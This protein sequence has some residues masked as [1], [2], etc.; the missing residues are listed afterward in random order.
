MRKVYIVGIGHT[1]FGNLSELDLD[2]V[3]IMAF[4]STEAM[5]DAGIRKK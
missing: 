2:L 4:A 1:N 3:D 5:D